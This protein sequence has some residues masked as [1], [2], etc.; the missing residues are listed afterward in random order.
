MGD[1]VKDPVAE[2]NEPDDHRTFP[3]TPK[4]IVHP[5]KQ[6]RPPDG[7]DKAVRNRVVI[8]VERCEGCISRIDPD[9][10]EAQ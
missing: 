3:F 10:F 5:P 6:H 8:K 1:Q 9:V 4:S 7:S 2:H